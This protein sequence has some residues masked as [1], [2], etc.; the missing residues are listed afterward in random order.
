MW[1]AVQALIAAYLR[2]GDFPFAEAYLPCSLAL[3]TEEHQRRRVVALAQCALNQRPFT[4]SIDADIQKL[5]TDV[6]V[7]TPA[8]D[9]IHRSGG[10]AVT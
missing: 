8:N 6:Y 7:A 1:L 5:D 10:G 4:A 3:A 9:R 2:A